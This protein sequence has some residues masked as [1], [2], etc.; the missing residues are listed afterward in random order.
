MTRRGT[1]A[2]KVAKSPKGKGEEKAKEKNN[3]MYNRLKIWGRNIFAKYPHLTFGLYLVIKLGQHIEYGPPR[4]A[5]KSI[6]YVITYVNIY[7]LSNI[8]FEY[9]V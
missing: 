4:P 2:W 9:V 3:V 6:K 5:F 1:T 7:L 8:I